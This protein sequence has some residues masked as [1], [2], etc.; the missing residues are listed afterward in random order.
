MALPFA[1]S[2]ASLQAAP[3][4]LTLLETFSHLSFTFCLLSLPLLPTGIS[5]F[6]SM[7]RHV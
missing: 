2:S 6:P 4:V 7:G 1:L 3:A 5:F